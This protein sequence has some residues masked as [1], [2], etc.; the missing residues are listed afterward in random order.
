MSEPTNHD[1]LAAIHELENGLE[2][3]FGARISSIESWR[4]VLDGVQPGGLPARVSGLETA[5][6]EQRGTVKALRLGAL[7]AG[8]GVSLLTLWQMVGPH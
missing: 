6:I 4:N 1:V 2:E 7:L 5:A 8:L 3:K